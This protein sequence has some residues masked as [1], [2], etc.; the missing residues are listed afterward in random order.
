MK[1][2]EKKI[3]K[4]ISR[5]RTRGGGREKPEENKEGGRNEI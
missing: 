2:K 5:G 1:M 3:D 4:P